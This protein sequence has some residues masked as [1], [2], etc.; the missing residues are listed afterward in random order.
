MFFFN[1]LNETNKS[2]LVG[3]AIVGILFFIVCSIFPGGNEYKPDPDEKGQR[4]VAKKILRGET[5]ADD[6]AAK[7]GYDPE[8]IGKWV[9]DYTDLAVKYALDSDKYAEHINLL[10]QDIVWFTK[11]CEKYI[12]ADWKEKTGFG[13]HNLDKY[14]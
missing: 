8:H 14:K 4:E 12:G 9:K 6:V 10:E 3:I 13:D 1:N 11:A 7:E 2:A 5:T